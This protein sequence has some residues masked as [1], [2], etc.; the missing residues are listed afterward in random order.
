M[1]N[2]TKSSRLRDLLRREARRWAREDLQIAEEWFELEEEAA[3]LL[4]RSES[5]ETTTSSAISSA[6]A[7]AKSENNG[8]RT[9]PAAQRVRR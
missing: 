2:Q 8:Q 6:I 5:A 1:T 9:K 7:P 3:Q 4:A